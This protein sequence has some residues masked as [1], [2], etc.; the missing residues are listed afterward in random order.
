MQKKN[1]RN[2]HLSILSIKL[3]EYD[4]T[5]IINSFKLSSFLNL[6]FSDIYITYSY[7][8]FVLVLYT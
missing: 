7:A 4:D 8:L 3:Y 5:S 6:F 2:D 1:D